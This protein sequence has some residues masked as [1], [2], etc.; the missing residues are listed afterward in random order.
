V[1]KCRGKEIKKVAEKLTQKPIL[2][3]E[4]KVNS[5]FFRVV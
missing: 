4:A 2:K 3:S 1:E 5:F